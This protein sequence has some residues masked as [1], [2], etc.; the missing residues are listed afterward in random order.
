MPPQSAAL[1][2]VEPPL[3]ADIALCEAGL[4]TELVEVFDELTDELTDELFDELFEEDWLLI[5]PDELDCVG[6]IRPPP[7][8]P[9]PPAKSVVVPVA[10]LATSANPSANAPIPWS[11]VQAMARQLAEIVWREQVHF[12]PSTKS[13]RGGLCYA[14]PRWRDDKLSRE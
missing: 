14:S 3:A 2:Q 5:E 10:Q 8:P 6:P 4:V 12:R 1:M 13:S 7:A 9:S 11:R